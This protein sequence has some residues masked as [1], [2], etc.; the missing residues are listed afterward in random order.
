MSL[1]DDIFKRNCRQILDSPLMPVRAHW[2]DTGAQANC[3]VAVNLFNSYDL[4]QE[5][6]ILTLRQTRLRPAMDEILWI[7]Q[8]KSNNVHALDS[9]IWDAWADRDGSI[10]KAYG[11]QIRR[12]TRYPEGDFDQIDKV[13]YD[14][15]NNPFSRRIM[16]NTYTVPDLPE[17]AL[18]PCAYSVTYNVTLDN[19]GDKVLNALLNQRSNDFLV[20]NNW[21]VSQYALLLMMLAHVTGMIPGRLDHVIANAHIYDRHVPMIQKLLQRPTYP[22]PRI[23]LDNHDSFYDYSVNDLRIDNYQFGPSLGRIPVAV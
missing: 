13:I 4:R 19:N 5:F 17:M 10:G 7:Y 14:L 8:R 23:R 20:A 21:N 12:I 3:H 11:Y 2:P 1:A 22:A 9:H 16:T 6:P 18:Y 15:I